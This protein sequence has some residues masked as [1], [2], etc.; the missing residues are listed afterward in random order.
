MKNTTPTRKTKT[1]K[2]MGRKPRAKIARP[3]RYTAPD[4]CLVKFAKARI[5][6]FDPEAA[7]ACVPSGE[8]GK[9]FKYAT[10]AEVTLSLAVGTG[11]ILVITTNPYASRNDNAALSW[12]WG[13]SPSAALSTIVPT[14][15]GSTLL[16]GS[17]FDWQG[18]TA[19]S[20]EWRC[21]GSALQVRNLGAPL[22]AQ[23]MATG[24]YN[25]NTK[26][27]YAS[28]TTKASDVFGVMNAKRMP[29]HELQDRP[30]EIVYDSDFY[31]DYADFSNSSSVLTASPTTISGSLYA[32]KGVVF[33]PA[34]TLGNVNVHLK[35][36][37]H[38]EA[39]GR[40]VTPIGSTENPQPL[41]TQTIFG[42]ASGVLRSLG[43][44]V[45]TM[46]QL[47]YAARFIAA[48]K[49]GQVY[50]PPTITVD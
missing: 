13:I 24:Y 17:P 11:N 29:M 39:R 38:C 15:T 1:T 23:G 5:A 10:F 34:D 3:L 47:S 6:P 20:L 32:G 35:Y 9:T 27:T 37:C 50:H 19:G 26:V 28:G 40:T 30:F 49:A 12:G 41:E 8:G 45:P 16:Y 33:I 14:N 2:R 25:V 46:G 22:Y 21:V 48:I 18:F 43:P 36:I 44:Y 7:G 4:P 42:R 31:D